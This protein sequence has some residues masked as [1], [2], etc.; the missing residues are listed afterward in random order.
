MKLTDTPNKVKKIH[1]LNF[2]VTEVIWLRS[3][4]QSRMGMT[5]RVLPCDVVRREVQDLCEFALPSPNNS[6]A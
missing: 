5:S 6:R 4:L 3:G 1:S 2:L